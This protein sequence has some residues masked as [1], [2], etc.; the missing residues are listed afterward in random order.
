MEIRA[1]EYDGEGFVEAKYLMTHDDKPAWACPA[2]EEAGFPEL[3]GPFAN[4][5][6]AEAALTKHREYL[7]WNG[8]KIMASAA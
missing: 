5:A 7:E 2:W 3:E 1:I 4:L 6:A 8:F